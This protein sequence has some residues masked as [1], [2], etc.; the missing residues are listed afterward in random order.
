MAGDDLGARVSRTASIAL[1]VALWALVLVLASHESRQPQ[2]LGRY[3]RGYTAFLLGVACCASG[4]TALTWAGAR[5]WARRSA[6][7]V[8]ALALGGVVSLAA[9]EWGLRHFDP[10][11]FAYYRE[12]SRYLD[13]RVP[14]EELLFVQPDG[15]SHVLDGAR[16]R[17]NSHRMRGP[18]PP[19]D[20]SVRRIL[21]LGDSVTFGW[22]VEE[23]E[24]FAAR[25]PA[26]LTE[27]AG[28]RWAGL[29]AGV[30]SYNTRQEAAW[31][32]RDG[33]ALDPDLVVLTIVDNDVLDL[34]DKWSQEAGRQLRLA[35]RIHT[36]LKGSYVYKLLLHAFNH[37]PDGVALHGAHQDLPED[38][39]GWVSSLESLR[40]IVEACES[41]GVPLRLVYYRPVKRPFTDRY[42]DSIVRAVAPRTV[43]DTAPW[44]AAAPVEDWVNSIVDSHP[45]ASAHAVF[46]ERLIASGALDVRPR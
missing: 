45:N 34:R 1:A 25:I 19:R 8:A 29:N 4:A 13:L 42:L 7:R 10:L 20:P 21:F 43:L 39:P 14:D 17:F 30:C 2:V 37:G 9:A 11:G 36:A 12:V 26:L 24:T 32:A 23:A 16:V 40:A 18:E 5:R 27:A 3:S 28:T 33:F 46:A 31:L 44:F 6:P 22:G 35:Q 38:D 15:G 41:R